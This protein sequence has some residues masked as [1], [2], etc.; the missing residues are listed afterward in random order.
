[1]TWDQDPPDD[2]DRAM[3]DETRCNVVWEREG[4]GDRLTWGYCAQRQGHAGLHGPTPKPPVPSPDVR[5]KN[6]EKT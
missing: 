2:L 5:P 6:G 3:A 1:M 4:S